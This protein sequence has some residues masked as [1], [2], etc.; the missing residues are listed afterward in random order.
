MQDIFFAGH[1]VRS[2]EPT[3]S[4]SLQTIRGGN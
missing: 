4:P 2:V 1:R 3:D